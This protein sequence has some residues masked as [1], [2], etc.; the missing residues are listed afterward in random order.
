MRSTGKLPSRASSSVE[1]WLAELEHPC[2]DDLVRLRQ[3]LQ[4]AVPRLEEALERGAPVF[5]AS[6]CFATFEVDGSGARLVLFR[7][8]GAPPLELD[9]R[10]SSLLHW[11]SDR[12]AVVEVD[13]RRSRSQRAPLATL[14]RR[15]VASLG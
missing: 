8:K 11:R 7:G 3:V 4:E 9:L 6:K 10:E 1:V 14:V 12:E 15:W 5:A 13:A 2:R